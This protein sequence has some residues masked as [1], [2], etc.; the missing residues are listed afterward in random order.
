MATWII[1]AKSHLK[2][3]ALLIFDE[4]MTGF[5]LGLAGAQGRFGIRR[6]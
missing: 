4:V 2:T 6:T 1:S 5:R 3:G